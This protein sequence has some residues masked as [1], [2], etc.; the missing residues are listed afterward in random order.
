MNKVEEA[1]K[2]YQEKEHE[3]LKGKAMAKDL[4][5]A[6][7]A[8]AEWYKN[9]GG[10]ISELWKRSIQLEGLYTFYEAQEACPVGYR[11][12]TEEEWEW[13]LKN[14]KYHFDKETKEGVF[15]L[16]DGFELRLPAAGRRFGNGDFGNQGTRGHYWPS[17]PSGT[18]AT[19]VF[20]NDGT[21]GVSTYGRFNAFSVRCV[22][23]EIEKI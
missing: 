18:I 23:I 10:G 21:A 8:G 1:A 19:N 4:Q 6:F 16:P 22:P 13:L 14:S 17:S 12:P 7:I 20:F 5:A 11:L 9:T 2:A 3:I 15:L